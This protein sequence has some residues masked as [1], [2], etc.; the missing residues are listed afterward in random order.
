LKL[1]TKWLSDLNNDWEIV[2]PKLLFSE[3]KEKNKPKDI[4][5]TPS[6]I[7]GVLPQAEYMEKTGNSVVLNLA[8]A[9]NMKHVEP[10]DFIIHL[11]SFQGG[12]EHSR[13]EGKVSNAY[14]VLSPIA[15]I[16]PRYFRWVMKSNGYIQEL[17][18][19]TDQ[20]RDGQS[21]KFDQFA[22]IGLPLPP[23]PIQSQIADYLDEKL[24]SID[25]L[26]Q[27]NLRI[28]LML[29]ELD[30]S[31][32]FDSLIENVNFDAISGFEIQGR[33]RNWEIVPLGTVCSEVKNKNSNLQENNLLSL[34]YGR[35]IQKDIESSEGLLPESF[36]GYNVVDVGDVVLR[37]TDLQ[38][39][40][41]SLR[42][43]FVEE[44][45]IITSAYTTLRSDSLLP[46][47]LS[48]QLKA[49]DAAKFFYA[50]GGGLRQSMKFDD[51]KSLP[52]LVPTLAEQ[53]AFLAKLD[54]EYEGTEKVRTCIQKQVESLKQLKTS[55][56]TSTI[57]GAFKVETVG[58]VA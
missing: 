11:R 2:S 47:F 15:K 16:E 20:L 39:D 4:H 33:V 28:L 42:V 46:A 9:D 36:D 19:T 56:I 29:E 58:R 24:V 49:F 45:G 10:N 26:I 31:F 13:Y 57:V 41:R 22:S 17:N 48:Y 14:C 35:I 34:S 12:I 23:L 18:A 32:A 52:I 55:L 21:I 3:R 50:L 44:R 1:S 40:Q 8:G 7:Y 6:Q 51:L 27:T 54:K 38:N 5:L 53:E 43:G 25:A 30:R 37:L